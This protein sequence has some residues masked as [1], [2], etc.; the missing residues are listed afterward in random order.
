MFYYLIVI[1][2]IS[3]GLV[4][5]DDYIIFPYLLNKKNKSFDYFN[6]LL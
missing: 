2:I 1:I 5:L 6:Q 3:I 4:L